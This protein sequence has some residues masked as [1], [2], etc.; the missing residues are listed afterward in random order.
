[1]EW[2]MIGCIPLYTAL[3]AGLRIAQGKDLGMGDILRYSLLGGGLTFLSAIKTG[4]VSL[5]DN[6]PFKDVLSNIPALPTLSKVEDVELCSDFSSEDSELIDNFTSLGFDA[7]PE[8][9]AISIAQKICPTLQEQIIGNERLVILDTKLVSAEKISSEGHEGIKLHYIQNVADAGNLNL[10]NLLEVAQ[11]AAKGEIVSITDVALAAIRDFFNDPMSIIS[12][13]P[14]T[15]KI[16]K[17]M[18]GTR[19]V[20]LTFWNGEYSA[21]PDVSG[22][23]NITRSKY[24]NTK[25]E[26]IEETMVTRSSQIEAKHLS[27]HFGD[28]HIEDNETTEAIFKS[29]DESSSLIHIT[30]SKETVKES[31]TISEEDYA[32]Y[33]YKSWV[34]GAK[35]IGPKV[36]HVDN[37]VREA[38]YFAEN[39][40]IGNAVADGKLTSDEIRDLN[41]ETLDEQKFKNTAQQTLEL[42][43]K[44]FQ[45]GYIDYVPLGSIVTLGSKKLQGFEVETSDVLWATVDG[46]SALATF[47]VASVA[48]KGGITMAKTAAKGV[49]GVANATKGARFGEAADKVM[50]MGRKLGSQFNKTGLDMVKAPGQ[51]I[52]R[53][54]QSAKEKISYALTHSP[55]QTLREMG[56]QVTAE[57]RQF[58]NVIMG[59]NVNRLDKI[60]GLAPKK[61]PNI[62]MKGKAVPFRDTELAKAHPEGIKDGD[63]SAYSQKTVKIPYTGERAKDFVLADKAAG[64]NKS[65]REQHH[66]TWHHAP[67]GRSM[68]LV[69]SNLHKN[70]AHTGGF[71]L[72]KAQV[73]NV[74][75]QSERVV[76][77]GLTAAKIEKG[78]ET[79]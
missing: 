55:S 54:I 59:K 62:A 60:Y 53:E 20:S 65:F 74:I 32:W 15:A 24:S 22:D 34:G 61:Q 17:A 21:T 9:L 67:D 4:P 33:H 14:D 2:V 41:I 51:T 23:R 12:A 69:D 75:R 26:T 68:H 3:G 42:G 40:D 43:K 72:H 44:E 39:K 46:V 27:I 56:R 45:S 7:L 29:R 63:F 30:E 36:Q 58:E 19:E 37:E 16:I 28:V 76:S 71:G 66:L 38:Y 50:N 31:Q 79:S 10:P 6:F 70:V 1:M 48:A 11:A 13:I 47:G 77:G 25:S 73:E 57:G 5:P 35:D 18:R 52:R 64:I 49:K 78:Q 8:P